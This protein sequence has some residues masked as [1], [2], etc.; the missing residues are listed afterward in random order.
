[1]LRAIL[2]S[3]KFI[4]FFFSGL[5]ILTA[6]AWAKGTT[7]DTAGQLS[8]APENR[9]SSSPQDEAEPKIKYPF[10]NLLLLGLDENN[11]SDLM[12]IAS[13]NIKTHQTFL[14][15]I[16]R[17]TYVSGHNWWQDAGDVQSQLCMANYVGMHP[18]GDYHRGAEFTALWI[19]YLIEIPIHEYVSVDFNSFKELIN[20]VG[21]VMLYVDPAFAEIR[22][23][24]DHAGL[25][26]LSAGLQRLDGRQA[27]FYAR[28]RGNS[29][30][31]RIPEPG[32][33]GKDGDRIRRNQKLLKA[34]FE[35]GRSLKFLELASILKQVPEKVHTSLDVWDMAAL[36]PSV[37]NINADQL[38]TI[39]LPGE[40]KEVYVEEIDEYTSY[41]Y[42]DYEKTAAILGGFGLR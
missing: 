22:P 18:D 38:V 23:G 4:F 17:D 26:P 40:F 34:L 29:P 37:K 36:A 32:S 15:A 39:V 13:Y 9:E 6:G 2:A 11:V 5:I 1:M 19:E 3:R 25:E 12:M 7:Y 41:F 27:F 30:E 35:Q 16:P 21:G 8:A 10:I 14:I 28:Y 24:G 42:V 31:N 20:M 33:P